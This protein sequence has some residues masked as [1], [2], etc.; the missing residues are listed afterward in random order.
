MVRP[1]ARALLLAIN[2]HLAIK[3]LTPVFST[4]PFSPVVVCHPA[5]IRIDSPGETGKQTGVC[6][7]SN[8]E[9]YRL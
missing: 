5:Q 8:K 6:L 9:P 2:P 4:S 1:T 3:P 7:H